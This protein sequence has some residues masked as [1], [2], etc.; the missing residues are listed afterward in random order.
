[1][2]CH[3]HCWQSV[4]TT[5]PPSWATAGVSWLVSHV[6]SCFPLSLFWE[7][8]PECSWKKPVRSC[9]FTTQNTLLTSNHRAKAKVLTMAYSP[10]FT[11][12]QPPTPHLLSPTILQFHILPQPCWSPF[13][14]S[15]KPSTCVSLTLPQLST[16]CS[17]C[18]E[19]FSRHN[20]MPDFLGS[21]GSFLQYL[22]GM[23]SFD[24][25]F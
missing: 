22:S 20:C 15:N 17:F 7:Q 24:Y 6:S 13:Y 8:Q 18:L 25:S 10:W 11:L 21:F 23:S 16:C 14:S 9:R 4:Q 12:H 3:L 5:T 1:M 19:C 2:H